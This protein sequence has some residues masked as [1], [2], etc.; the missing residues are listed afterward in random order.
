MLYHG[1]VLGGVANVL[2]LIDAFRAA[3]GAPNAEFG[4]EVE[5]ARLG[6]ERLSPGGE[7]TPD[8][9]PFVYQGLLGDYGLGQHELIDLPLIV[10]RLSV[11]PR[12]EFDDIIRLI[13]VDIHDAAGSRRTPP[14]I[15]LRW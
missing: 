4:I 12:E 14:S 2:V 9:T 5:V 11:G 10:P 8:P 3:A 15:K 6:P 1:W 13:D 7:F